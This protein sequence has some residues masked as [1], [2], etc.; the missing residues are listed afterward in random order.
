ME[1]RAGR[2][3]RSGAPLAGGLLLHALFTWALYGSFS[4]MAVYLGAGPQ[5][6]A[7]A[8][9]GDWSAYVAAWPGAVATA[10]GYLLDQKD[11]LLAYG[12]HFLLALVGLGWLW[13][14]KRGLVVMLALVAA[15]YVGP[16]AL[17]QQLGDVNGLRQGSLWTKH[18]KGVIPGVQSYGCPRQLARLLLRLEQGRLVDPWSSREM[19]RYLYMT[20]KRY[21]YAYPSELKD[22]AVYFK[23]GSLYSCQKEEGFRPTRL[24]MVMIVFRLSRA[25]ASIMAL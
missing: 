6:G 5:D 19:K 18:G 22:A 9:G 24:A 23:S 10:I 15:S 12:P 7:P 8:L 21:R 3:W 13:R 16:Y 2:V 4:P 14:R 11:G 25:R 17:S 20:K 1:A